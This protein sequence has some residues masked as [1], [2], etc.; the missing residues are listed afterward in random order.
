MPA[1]P[2]DP[3]GRACRSRGSR[4]FSRRRADATPKPA[5]ESATSSSM[6]RDCEPGSA[7]RRPRGLSRGFR[8]SGSSLGGQHGPRRPQRRDLGRGGRLYLSWANQRRDRQARRIPGYDRGFLDRQR[9][10]RRGRSRNAGAGACR[11]LPLAADTSL[12]VEG[13]HG[14]VV[15]LAQ[16]SRVGRPGSWGS[17]RA[18]R[19]APFR[20][21][22]LSGDGMIASA[23]A[24]V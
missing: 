10:A 15:A 21:S 6:S 11:L 20:W 13:Y 3:P 23:A 14:R 1:M 9:T 5:S 12:V 22:G 8:G 24:V 2:Y 7:I 17:E 19:R 4:P 18:A 16:A